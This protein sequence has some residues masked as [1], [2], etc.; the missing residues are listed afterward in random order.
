MHCFFGQ[1]LYVDIQKQ[2]IKQNN[3]RC[4]TDFTFPAVCFQI[5]NV[6]KKKVKAVSFIQQIQGFKLAITNHPCICPRPQKGEI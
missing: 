6:N 5:H 1:A 2:I 3:Q 4:T